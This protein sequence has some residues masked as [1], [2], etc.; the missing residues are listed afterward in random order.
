MG[1]QRLRQYIYIY[2]QGFPGGVVV[3]NLLAN[4]GDKRDASFDPWVRKVPL[5]KGMATQFSALV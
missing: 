3:K 5:E 1:I 4:A 2:I